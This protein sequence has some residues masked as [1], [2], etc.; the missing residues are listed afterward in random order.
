M[1]GT[2]VNDNFLLLARLQGIP[3]YAPPGP[4]PLRTGAR[5][6]TKT[7]MVADRKAKRESK[8]KA[9][10]EKNHITAA[11]KVKRSLRSRRS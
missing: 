10:D 11:C 5:V 4:G 9:A 2:P 8:Q 3:T 6:P 1:T 7:Q